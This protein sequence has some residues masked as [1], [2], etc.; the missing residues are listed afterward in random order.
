MNHEKN[1]A[2]FEKKVK[3]NNTG[4]CYKTRA[5]SCYEIFEVLYRVGVTFKIKELSSLQLVLVPY[6]LDFTVLKFVFV[7]ILHLLFEL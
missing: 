3:L 2:L 1:T 5:L 7:C 4:H 6:Q